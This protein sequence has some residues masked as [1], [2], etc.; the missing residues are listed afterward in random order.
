MVHA[1]EH[2]NFPGGSARTSTT[3]QGPDN[4][5]KP[6]YRHKTGMELGCR[7]RRA[8][9]SR[10]RKP[11][12]RCRPSMDHRESCSLRAS[13]HLQATFVL[14]PGAFDWA[15]DRF[16]A[17]H[18]SKSNEGTAHRHTTAITPRAMPT[19]YSLSN[20]YRKPSADLNRACV[21][22]FAISAVLACD[23]CR[24]NGILDPEG[25]SVTLATNTA[26]TIAASALESQGAI[27]GSITIDNRN[28]FDVNDP[29]EDKWL[30]RLANRIH[31]TTR[32]EVIRSQLLFTTNEPY[33]EHQVE[34][35]ERLLR[36]NSYIREA[37]VT[38]VQYADGIVDLNVKTNDVWT[39]TPS[40]SLGRSGGVNSGGFGIKEKN[41][42]GTG[43]YAGA[44]YKTTV[45]RDT[46]AFDFGTNNF[47]SSRLRVDAGLA[48]NS[49]G[50]ERLLHIEQP[51]YA[52][53]SRRAGGLTFST[54]DRT[55]SFYDRGNIVGGYQH[56]ARQHEIYT[57]W[58]GGL[59]NGW[60]RRL[61]S[62][63]AYDEHRFQ[64][65]TDPSVPALAIPEDRRFLYPFVGID[66]VEDKFETAVNMDQINRTEDRFIGRRVRMRLG[67]SSAALGSSKSA[68]HFDNRFENGFQ[69][70]RAQ[71]LVTGVT[72]SGRFEDGHAAN[73]LLSAN[74]AYHLRQSPGRLLFASVGGSFGTSLDLDNQLL[75]GG[76]NGLRGYPLRYQGG[77]KM[78]LLT[79]EQRFY[80]DWYLFRLFHVGAA[81]FFDAGRTW[82]DNPAGGP[83]LGLLRD[84]GLGLRLGNARSSSGRV[85]H[86]DLAYPLDGEQGI[87]SLQLL[88]AAKQSF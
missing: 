10:Q 6:G 39:L 43:S 78:A 11:A 59:T 35:S 5:G 41:L 25:G 61:T 86:L 75:L 76:D 68:W 19:G 48:S 15:R 71:N 16:H 55:D 66:F 7:R 74:A 22:V 26:G 87:S 58:A 46:F 50:Y 28:I 67:Y 29:L 2:P 24:A 36:Q 34:E 84:I 33:S 62:G 45:D 4:A 54:F 14:L 9:Y 73:V 53:E 72:L 77:D 64:A 31:V 37:E 47:R 27:I 65:P 42:F 40:V 69:L 63:I 18:A 51:F 52:L 49:D 82:G 32:P 57:G 88:I 79:L 12:M 3:V 23:D 85:M 70:S 30:F 44:R 83:N 21:C 38:A 8:V 17:G 1:A 56:A 80:T 20:R 81:V 60:A 13:H